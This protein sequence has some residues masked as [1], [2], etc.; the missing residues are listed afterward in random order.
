MS[1]LSTVSPLSFAEMTKRCLKLG[2][3]PP[4]HLEDLYSHATKNP[5]GDGFRY[6]LVMTKHKKVP[7]VV[8][9]L[10]FKYSLIQ[11][12]EIRLLGIPF[13]AILSVAG[14]IKKLAKSRNSKVTFAFAPAL[15]YDVTG[16]CRDLHLF[17]SL[18]NGTICPEGISR[19]SLFPSQW[20]LGC[21]FSRF[22]YSES[23]WHSY[24][25]DNLDTD[26][27]IRSWIQYFIGSSSLSLTDSSSH[28]SQSP[29]ELLQA[30]LAHLCGGPFKPNE[31]RR[32]GPQNM[33]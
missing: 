16:G 7:W 22:R 32:S 14:S 6:F 33:N 30:Q 4:I 27:H 13:P 19:D 5:W 3:P 1:L 29:T 11:P 24:V 20:D 12:D 28:L 9:R 17:G 15:C 23:S 25:K 10:Q 18:F 31:Y 2:L 26:E 8:L 21:Y